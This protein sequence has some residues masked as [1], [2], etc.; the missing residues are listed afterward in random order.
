MTYPK[1]RII[2]MVKN[3]KLHARIESLVDR[4]IINDFWDVVG[5][6]L[7]SI[8]GGVPVSFAQTVGGSMTTKSM[9]AERG[10]WLWRRGSK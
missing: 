1:V 10:K 2:K 9:V 5:D 8:L 6:P 4:A 7:L 3:Q